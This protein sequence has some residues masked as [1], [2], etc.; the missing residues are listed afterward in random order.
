MNVDLR[1][2]GRQLYLGGPICWLAGGLLY[3]LNS[4]DINIKQCQNF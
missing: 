1:H 4:D 2:T 3:K